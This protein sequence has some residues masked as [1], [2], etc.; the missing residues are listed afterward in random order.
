MLSNKEVE[1]QFNQLLRDVET[2]E[3]YT[4]IDLSNRVNCYTCQQCGH[5]TK[6][7]D[8]HAGVTPF[9]YSCESCGKTAVSSF[10]RDIAP[11]LKPTIEWYR[12]TL[13]KVL[14]IRA[15]NPFLFDH[16][17]SGGLIDRKIISNG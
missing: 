3:F 14:T 6:T 5:I 2:K 1:K 10:Y 11:S 8:I 7:I 12:P 9:M 13:E 15:N 4:R 17:L 16:I